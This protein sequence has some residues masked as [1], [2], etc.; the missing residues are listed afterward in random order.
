MWYG[1]VLGPFRDSGLLGTPY[2]PLNDL[3]GVKRGVQKDPK[4]R[5]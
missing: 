2:V 5:D 4:Y 1:A 3:N